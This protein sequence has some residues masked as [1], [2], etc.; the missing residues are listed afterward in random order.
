LENGFDFLDSNF[1]L[2]EL[3][4]LNQLD[5]QKLDSIFSKEDYSNDVIK[6]LKRFKSFISSLLN[7]KQE[8]D[9]NEN[10]EFS[11]NNIFNEIRK[12]SLNLDIYRRKIL[13]QI[14][15]QDKSSQIWIR[16]LIQNSVDAIRNT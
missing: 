15:G 9:K 13:S 2:S 5:S 8:D 12:K 4:Y 14:D 7:F 6:Y 11:L 16:E 3:I 10:I 1:R